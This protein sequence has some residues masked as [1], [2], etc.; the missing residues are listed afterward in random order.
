MIRTSGASGP[1]LRRHGALFVQRERDTGDPRSRPSQSRRRRPGP[2]EQDF[3]LHGERVVDGKR[4]TDATAGNDRR[5]TGIRERP[6]PD[7]RHGC[8]PAGSAGNGCV[9]P[10]LVR[11]DHRMRTRPHRDRPGPDSSRSV[12]TRTISA[13]WRDTVPTRPEDIPVA[14][15]KGPHNGA[16]RSDDT[17]PDL[18]CHPD[19]GG[20]PWTGGHADGS[21]AGTGLG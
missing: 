10:H 2:S 12:R 8:D 15:R 13:I 19:R 5:T 18:I 14:L 4:A 6:V 1:R 21:D 9:S 20:A 3:S 11:L 7:V 17:D 16:D